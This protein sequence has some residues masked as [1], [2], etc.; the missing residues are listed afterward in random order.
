MQQKGGKKN[1]RNYKWISVPPHMR[2]QKLFMTQF[3]V[4]EHEL[5]QLRR[6]VK[7]DKKGNKQAVVCMCVCLCACQATR[8][9]CKNLLETNFA[10][11]KLNM[12]KF[13]IWQIS[14]CF[15]CCCCC[16]C[17]CLDFVYLRLSGC[18]QVIETVRAAAQLPTSRHANFQYS[19]EDRRIW[20]F[21]A[22]H[23]LS[24]SVNFCRAL[25][26]NL[27]NKMQMISTPF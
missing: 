25:P 13:D 27:V 24:V 15:C 23:L 19:T 7:H 11:R 6:R 10:K 9:M 20:H 16:C 4:F 17:H 1:E 8:K 18:V 26:L 21:I 14:C 3:V 22:I 2:N 5:L 12:A